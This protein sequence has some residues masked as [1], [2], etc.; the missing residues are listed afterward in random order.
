MSR[1]IVRI[2]SYLFLVRPIYEINFLCQAATSR[3]FYVWDVNDNKFTE[4]TIEISDYFPPKAGFHSESQALQDVMVLNFSDDLEH[5]YYVDLASNDY[6]KWSNTYVLDL[7]N[8]W[9]G[10]CIEANP[11]YYE[12]I[13]GMFE[14]IIY[15]Y[16]L[17][18]LL[19]IIIILGFRGCQLYGNPVGSTPG[20]R[21]EFLFTPPEKDGT[22]GG[23]VSA[24][25]DNKPDEGVSTTTL[26]T[27]TLESILYHAKAPSK[28]DYLSLDI[29]GA[30]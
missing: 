21:V 7:F 19:L 25:F 4:K 6:K 20:E 12:N 11:Q 23:I 16:Y 26:Y 24:D 10:V 28:I 1:L 5:G 8:Y 29:E 27:A 2:L 14:I 30:E 18:S 15:Y 13:L 17:L 22:E 3:P 9:K